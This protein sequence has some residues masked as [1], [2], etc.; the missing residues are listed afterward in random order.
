MRAPDTAARFVYLDEC[1]STNTELA[2]RAQ[3]DGWPDFSVLVTEN[4]TGGRGRLGRVWVAP[5]GRTLA[6]SVLLRPRL[7]DG[8]EL[9]LEN[10]GWLPLIAGL[11]MTAAVTPLVPSHEVSLKWPNDVLIDGLKVAGLLAELSAD[12]TSVVMG[13]GLNVTMTA[14]EL[15]TATS[16]SL[17][18]K[19]AVPDADGLARAALDSYLT[20]LSRLYRQFLRAADPA[21]T[22]ALLARHCS[23]LGRSVRV[24]L[25]GGADL[26]G[27]ATAIDETG[28][29]IVRNSADDHD[30]AV[31]AGDVTHL[32]YE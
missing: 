16:T 17:V 2:T 14:E 22:A 8:S 11:A 29:L 24:Q 19:D 20:N 26:F 27:T 3:G 23:T 7:A 1:A 30:V 31:A 13:A 28:R 12:G 32:R 21:E 5:P 18:I 25:P 6:V 15:P 9:G 4:Q 10:F